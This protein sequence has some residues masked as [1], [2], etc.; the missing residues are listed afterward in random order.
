MNERKSQQRNDADAEERQRN[1]NS[2]TLAESMATFVFPLDSFS[3]RDATYT[4]HV[5]F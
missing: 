5:L 2:E 3:T 4:N 1:K